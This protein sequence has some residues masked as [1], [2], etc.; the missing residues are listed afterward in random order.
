M[1]YID[2]RPRLT[3]LNGSRP[4]FAGGLGDDALGGSLVSLASLASFAF[5]TELACD[6]W[7]VEYLLE[8]VSCLV[9][10]APEWN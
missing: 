8:R 1:A 2:Q 10:G 9:I 4:A 6:G 3:V 7:V 5:W